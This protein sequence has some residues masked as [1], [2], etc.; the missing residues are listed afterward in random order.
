VSKISDEQ[1]NQI[2]LDF[3]HAAPDGY[4][5][6][7][8]AFKRNVLAIWICNHGKFSYTDKHPIKSIWGFYN[9]KT[10]AFHAPVNSGIMGKE[11]ERTTPYSAMQIKLTPLEAAYV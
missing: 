3:P 9:S 8:T 5:Y 7:V 2:A 11:V 6:E 1:I 4:S 10:R